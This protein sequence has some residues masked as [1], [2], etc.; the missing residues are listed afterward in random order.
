MQ[1]ANL[2]PNKSA[3]PFAPKNGL[4]QNPT[5]DDFEDSRFSCNIFSDITTNPIPPFLPF[6]LSSL[7]S[8]PVVISCH[9]IYKSNRISCILSEDTPKPS[10]IFDE[11]RWHSPPTT[12]IPRKSIQIPPSTAKF[13]LDDMEGKGSSKNHFKKKHHQILA[14][15][16][17]GPS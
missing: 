17:P 7:K 15:W 10:S 4:S 1:G 8:T 2:D 14:A 12:E 9:Y 11:L 5:C 13:H 3:W 6:K 16:F